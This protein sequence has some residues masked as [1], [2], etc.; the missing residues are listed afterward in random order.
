MVLQNV[1]IYPPA[2]PQSPQFL[3]TWDDRQIPPIFRVSRLWRPVIARSSKSPESPGSGDRGAWEPL[4]SLAPGSCDYIWAWEQSGSHAPRSPEPGDS[5]DLY[6]LRTRLVRRDGV[7]QSWLRR[8]GEESIVL[9][10]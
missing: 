5:G 1:I 4:G 3:E 7:G 6:R 2:T 9:L 10:L 8:G